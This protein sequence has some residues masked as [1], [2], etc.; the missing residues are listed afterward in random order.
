MTIERRLWVVASFAACVQ[1]AVACRGP[2]AKPAGR[3]PRVERLAILRLL[4]T[5]VCSRR[6]SRRCSG[7]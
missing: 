2:S 1:F 3:L 6:R 5:G 7:A 4:R